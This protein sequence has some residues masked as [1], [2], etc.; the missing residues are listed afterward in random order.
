MSAL[1]QLCYRRRRAVVVAWIL[2]VVGLAAAALSLGTAFTTATDLPDSESSRAHALMA[3]AGMSSDTSNGTI[4]WRSGS[5]AIDA[6]AVRAEAAAMLDEIAA[7][8][9]V[10]AVV[11]PYSE[12]GVAQVNPVLSTAFATVTATDDVDVEQVRE[13]VDSCATA[14]FEVAAGGQAFSEMPAPS[15]GTEAIGIIAAL[16]ILLLVFRSGWAA[17]LPILTGV[18]GVGTSLLAVIVGAHVVDLDATSLT[19]GALI[20]LGVGIDYALFIVNRYRKALIAGASVPQA[21]SQS[22]NTSGRAVVF[23]GLTVV[24]ALLGMFVVGLGVLTGMGQA[25][26]VTVLFTVAAA[27]TL[28]PALLGMLGTKV[29][30]KKQRTAIAAG[31]IIEEHPGRAPL[32]ARWAR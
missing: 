22:V 13:V 21:I 19:M 27:I 5:D 10:E 3:E 14:T 6:P 12:A 11:S 17:A 25:A 26:A 9:G 7:L 31:E 23:A 1:A 32:S 16:A 24:A 30:S 4:V 20:G 15:H 28:L 2:A 29:L 18:T 8:P